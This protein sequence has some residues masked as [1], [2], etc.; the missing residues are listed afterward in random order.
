MTGRDLVFAW[1]TGLLAIQ[2]APAGLSTLA[3]VA[4]A[5]AAALGWI[6]VS[7]VLR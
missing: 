6:A 7:R 4:I 2:V 3:Y 1:L 5:C